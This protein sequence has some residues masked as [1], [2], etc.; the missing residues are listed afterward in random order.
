MTLIMGLISGCLNNK[1]KSF[2]LISSNRKA[3]DKS[4][5]GVPRIFRK[6]ISKELTISYVSRKWRNSKYFETLL[7]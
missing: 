1:S 4:G 2:F 6:E 5:P 7:T 3:L